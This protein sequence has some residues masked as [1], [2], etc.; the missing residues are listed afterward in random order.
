MSYQ[1]THAE[2]QDVSASKERNRHFHLLR[3]VRGK[4]PC[5]T[6]KEENDRRETFGTDRDTESDSLPVGKWDALSRKRAGISCCQRSGNQT[7]PTFGR[8]EK[9]IFKKID[10]MVEIHIDKFR[11][12]GRILLSHLRHGKY[13]IKLKREKPVSFVPQV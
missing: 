2:N 6:R 11:P 5:I 8:S 9:I 13:P 3:S 10:Q 1:F 7:F 4:T 12:F